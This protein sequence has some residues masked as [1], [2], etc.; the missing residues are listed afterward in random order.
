M[1]QDRSLVA[2]NPF[3][4]WGT[5]VVI[6][7]PTAV[8]GYFFAYPVISIT[9]RG[10]APTGHIDPTVL[11]DVLRDPSLQ[12]V[13]AFT[14][15]QA[16]LSTFLTVAA[17]LPAAWVFARFDFP[18]RS[19]MRA[20][21]LVPF[22][23]PT[24]VVGTAFLALI[25]PRGVTG[26]DL[27]GTLAIILLAHVFYNYAIVVRGVG[28]YWERLDPSF[29][30]AARTLGASR[31]Q[32]FRT[33]TLPMLAPAIAS[34][35]ALVFLFSFTSFGVVLLLGDLSHSTIE[36]EIWRQT[37]AF[38]RLDVA[39]TLAVLQLIGVG[40][41]LVLYGRYQR[42]T[43]IQFK[44][45]ATPPPRPATTREK[46]AVW[47]VLGTSGLLLGLPMGILVGRSLVQPSGGIGLANYTNLFS[48]P[49]QSAAFADPLEAIGNSV[50]FA[51]AASIFALLVGTLA[52]AA[53]SY[54][55][56][57]VA[58]AFDVFVM[59]PLGTSAVTIGFGFLIAL[60]WPVDLRTSLIL[61]PIAHAL[62]AIPFVVR[63]TTPSMGS[64][65][66]HLRE[67]AATLGADPL[68]AW[69]TVDLPLV[70]RSI[71]V[72]AAF[73][74]AISMGEF[75][76]TAFIAR[77]ASPTI[78]IAIFRLLGR[79]G[80]APFGAAVALSV[81]LMGITG[82]AVLVMDSLRQPTAGDL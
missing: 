4:R 5:A 74:F 82:I 79:P 29:E 66:H 75:G 65:Q 67:A 60:D 25:G 54:S 81:I 71:F 47:T 51:V 17:G 12:G 21:T 44:H 50:G 43:A 80:A 57:R 33:V 11:F 13:A 22:V 24:L 64:V 55:R 63:T 56:R 38:L 69:K 10:L 72:G 39:S 23:L 52:S 61:I 1:D 62:V 48:L 59:L 76:A 30:E 49:D 15:W 16:V 26:V 58:R 6:A 45:R 42:R 14:L 28:T 9:Y 2:R 19:I 20:A 53:L 35:S 37:T 78:P 18:G 31:W 73:A 41:I 32:T 68:T 8:L 46:A 7:V 34:T 27:T 70:A 40:T 36:V 3:G 77:P